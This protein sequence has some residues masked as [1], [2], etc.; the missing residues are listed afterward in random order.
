MREKIGKALKARSE[1]IRTALKEYNAAA[2]QLGHPEMTWATVLKAVTLADFDL[3]RDTRN[4]IRSLPWTE[5]SR[6]EASMLHFGIQRAKE[7]I[8]R[9][10]IEI[11]R[12][13]TYMLDSHIEYKL[14]I[15]STTSTNP[16]L[17]YELEREW[18]HIDR[19]HRTIAHRLAQASR[20]KGFSGNIRT[21]NREGNQHLSSNR[22]AI[23]LPLWAQ[24][25]GLSGNLPST[26]LDT[27]HSS[28]S[29]LGMGMSD[30]E[31][32]NDGI[33]E[34]NTSRELDDVDPNTLLQLIE[35]ISCS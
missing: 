19:V 8:L 34:G 7:E 18:A 17:A 27:F 33:D 31:E 3:L 14:A 16:A 20:L 30:S 26:E 35:R 11:E 24:E 22:A 25:I 13:L 10:N 23:P 29:V 12:L 4:D 9:L 28:Q 5:P 2:A 1:A 32:I 21:G 6:R 15:S